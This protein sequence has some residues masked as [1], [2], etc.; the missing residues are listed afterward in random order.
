MSLTT[1]AASAV[2]ETVSPHGDT[3]AAL[4]AFWARAELTKLK[5]RFSVGRE[6]DV[7]PRLS[8]QALRAIAFQYRYFTQAFVTDLALLVVRCPEGRLRSLRLVR[9]RPGRPGRGEGDRSHGSGPPMSDYR[10]TARDWFLAVVLFVILVA[11]GIE[12]VP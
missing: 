11:A 8:I 5:A 1:H 7:L 4:E 3:R 2:V 9:A 6:M 12:R 10:P